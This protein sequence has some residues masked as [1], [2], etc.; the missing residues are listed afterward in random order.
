HRIARQILAAEDRET[1]PI[2]HRA[3]PLEQLAGGGQGRSIGSQGHLPHWILNSAMGGTSRF[4]ALAVLSIRQEDAMTPK[5]IVLV[6]L[7][8]VS[9]ARLPRASGEDRRP[10]CTRINGELVE[11]PG[12]ASS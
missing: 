3:V 4:F 6:A 2:D 5:M 8:A 11:D 9:G 7:F 10:R 1:A 12:D